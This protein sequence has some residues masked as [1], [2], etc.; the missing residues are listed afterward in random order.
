MD[1]VIQVD[2]VIDT[3]ADNKKR[4]LGFA[5]LFIILVFNIENRKYEKNH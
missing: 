5:L 1:I 2:E 4:I 3:F